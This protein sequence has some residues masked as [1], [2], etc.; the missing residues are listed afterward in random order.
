MIK[1]AA[2]NPIQFSKFE[3]PR[4]DWETYDDYLQHFFYEKGGFISFLSIG[5]HALLVRRFK[6][7]TVVA[8]YDGDIIAT[9]GHG[10]IIH[11]KIPLWNESGLFFFEAVNIGPS[12]QGRPPVREYRYSNVFCIKSKPETRD[13]LT[14]SAKNNTN[15]NNIWI[16]FT[17][18]LHLE[19]EAKE[20]TELRTNT[21]VYELYDGGI[22][23][24]DA[25]TINVRE[26][27]FGG[28]RGVSRY[29]ANAIRMYL[30]SD[31]IYINGDRYRRVSDP[32]FVEMDGYDRISVRCELKRVDDNGMWLDGNT[33]T[34][35]TLPTLGGWIL[36]TG[37]W[38]SVG[39]WNDEDTW[40]D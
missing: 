30:Y 34:P 37:F 32:E 21:T 8:E 10:D 12:L 23:D 24:L 26:F 31:E 18:E 25:K 17:P 40:I 33:E 35:V 16:G 19:F 28:K 36:R 3:V 13:Y 1:F 22:V 14:L 4:Y 7:N 20:K 29:L 6:D 38:D 15:R 2:Y 11:Y 27:S 9:I 39:T 5:V